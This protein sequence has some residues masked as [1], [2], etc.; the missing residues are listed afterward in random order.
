MERGDV[1]QP[2]QSLARTRNRKGPRLIESE[3]YVMAP[4]SSSF[5]FCDVVC[6]LTSVSFSFVFCFHM[7]LRQYNEP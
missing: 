4:T 6:R 7:E 2:E 3:I 1:C 5:V